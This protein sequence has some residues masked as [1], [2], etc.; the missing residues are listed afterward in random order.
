MMTIASNNND[1][2][3]RYSPAICTGAHKHRIEGNLDPKHVSTS[4]E[5][6][7]IFRYAWATAA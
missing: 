2:Q 7:K 6:V 5:S 1:G 3:R 4:F